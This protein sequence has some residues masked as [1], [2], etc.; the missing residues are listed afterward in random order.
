VEAGV[1]H[2][3]ASYT[4]SD[5]ELLTTKVG[6]YPIE[7]VRFDGSDALLKLGSHYVPLAQIKEVYEG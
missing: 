4:G 7:S 2:V 3:T 5:G 6:T 1:Y